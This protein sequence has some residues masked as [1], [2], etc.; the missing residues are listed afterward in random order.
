MT[1]PLETLVGLR[2]LDA[3]G[4]FVGPK[5]HDWQDGSAR[6]VLMRL[7][8][9]LYWFQE[10]PSDGYRSALSH[11]RIAGLA[12]VPPGALVEFPPRLVNCWIRTKPTVEFY[13]DDQGD[14]FY[15][16]QR[17]EI[18]VGV[19]EATNTILFEIGT[20][21]LDDYYPSFI[22]HWTPPSENG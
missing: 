15:T 14:E 21:N 9:V 22:S 10:D 11:V 16:D 6:V 13:T 7:N 5:E 18:L 2:L 1:V 12:D 19:D 17:D 8:G 4:E 3:R 20:D